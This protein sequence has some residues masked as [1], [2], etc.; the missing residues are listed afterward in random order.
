MAS[1]EDRS[2]HYT[3]QDPRGRLTG[4]PFATGS[5]QSVFTALIGSPPSTLIPAPPALGG[6]DSPSLS[7]A[8]V[9]LPPA[10]SSADVGLPPYLSCLLAGQRPKGS[11]RKAARSAATSASGRP[12]TILPSPRRAGSTQARPDS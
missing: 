10:P 12:S 6:Q 11:L 3:G 8:D 5:L 2:R 1:I 9:G 7:S 4:V